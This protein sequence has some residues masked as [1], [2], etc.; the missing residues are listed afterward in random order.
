[1]G[2]PDRLDY[3]GVEVPDYHLVKRPRWGLV[4]AGAGVGLGLFVFSIFTGIVGLS[5]YTQFFGPGMFTPSS[6]QKSEELSPAVL[7][8]PILGPFIMLGGPTTSL[9]ATLLV[10]DGLGQVAGL[11]L[12]VIGFAVPNRWLELDD[13]LR[14]SVGA[15]RAP[16]GLTVSGAL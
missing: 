3:T 11:A 8:I 4:G 2:R 14:V 9:S 6:T 16:L 12:A 15:P 7:F 1:M 13:R 10:L 5:G